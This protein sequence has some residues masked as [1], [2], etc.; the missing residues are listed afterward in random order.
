MGG[1]QC[2]P[3]GSGEGRH[4]L[5]GGGFFEPVGV[6]LGEDDVGVVEQPVDA[7]GREGGG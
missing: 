1:H 5:A 7:G 3:A 4:P 6:T 2:S